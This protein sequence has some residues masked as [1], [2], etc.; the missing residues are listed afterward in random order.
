LRYFDVIFSLFLT[1]FRAAGANNKRITGLECR[2]RNE[3][4]ET[5]YL[6]HFQRAMSKLYEKIWSWFFL[7]NP[8]KAW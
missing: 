6:L 5:D 2:V 7:W 4:P 8:A 3:D 1:V